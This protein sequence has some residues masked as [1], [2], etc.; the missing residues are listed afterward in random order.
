MMDGPIHRHTR[1]RAAAS[2]NRSEKQTNILTQQLPQPERKRNSLGRHSQS[3][4]LTPATDTSTLSHTFR[5]LETHFSD[6]HFEL[7]LHS[8]RH[9]IGHV[10]EM[11]SPANLLASIEETKPNTIKANIHLEHKY[12][13]TRNKHK[14]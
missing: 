3:W 4:L 6:S 13:T 11:F 12:T 10:G 8:T 1:K 2:R 9:E 7:I 14:N 5:H